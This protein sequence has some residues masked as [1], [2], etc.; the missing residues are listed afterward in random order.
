MGE[1]QGHRSKNAWNVALWIANDEYLYRTAIDCKRR[2]VTL[3]AA[4][5]QFLKYIGDGSKT[6]DGATYNY[7]CVKEAL[8]ELN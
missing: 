5:R 1:Y 6:P 4:T 8:R 7:T 3:S 2:C